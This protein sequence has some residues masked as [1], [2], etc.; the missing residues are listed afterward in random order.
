M[1]TQSGAD[2]VAADAGRSYGSTIVGEGR[3]NRILEPPIG[4]KRSRPKVVRF[5]KP[6]VADDSK[7]I[8]TLVWVL[9]QARKGKL[10]GYAMV[11]GV[12]TSEADGPHQRL[13]EAAMAFKEIDNMTVLGM[14]RRMES[15]YM[16]RTWPEDDM[17]D[18]GS[19]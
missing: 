2:Q 19:A 7:F 17:V 12:E 11:Y 4:R 5:K 3:L 6:I 1:G 18:K 14:I 16:R 10:I 15:N 9:S 13:S 8:E